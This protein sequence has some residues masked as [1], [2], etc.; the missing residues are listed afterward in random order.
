M[1]LV[2]LLISSLS[3]VIIK[4][5]QPEV[6]NFQLVWIIIGFLVYLIASRFDFRNFQPLW[7][8]FYLFSVILLILPFFGT[9]VRGAYRWVN[10]FSIPFQPSEIVKPFLVLSFAGFL[11][12]GK[13]FSAKKVLLFTF[14][15]LLPFL[16][17]FK[18]P[19]L[20]NALVYV[21]IF[22]ALL[23]AGGFKPLYLPVLILIF[24][25]NIPYIW[26]GLAE[27]QKLRLISFLTPQFDIKG[28]GYNAF[29]ALIAVGSG[30]LLGRGFGQGT[31]SRLRFLPEKHTDFIYA[32]L[33][34]ELG[35]VGGLVL[36]FLYLILFLKIVKIIRENSGFA[37]FVSLGILSQLFVQVC[38]NI[39]MNLGILPITGITLPL[40]S[41]GGSSVISTFFAL[42]IVSSFREK[43]ETIAI[44]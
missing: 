41:Y 27:Y 9:E 40:F 14:L 36:L 30:G 20:G 29:Q 35:F 11:A 24:G 19:D 6:F 32:S 4:S 18:Q 22:C 16:L 13:K 7:P 3:L 42:G 17:V 25:L 5:I 23:T 12:G 39:G 31:Q 33:A 43:E 26:K 28:A 44:G 21:F 8:L 15:F 10:I 38:I 37:Y 2:I 34:E 1:N